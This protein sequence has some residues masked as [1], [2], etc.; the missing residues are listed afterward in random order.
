MIDTVDNY[1]L[2]GCMRCDFGATP[3][4]K[5]LKWTDALKLLRQIVLDCGL[6]EEVKWG[7]PCYSYEGSNVLIL[8]A[9]VDYCSVNFFKGVLIKDADDLL[10]K[11]GPNSQSSR[12]MKFTDVQQIME[13]EDVLKS[14]IHQAIEVEKA[15]LKVALKKDPEPLPEELEL[16]FKE[17]PQF[18]TAF[19]SLTP[20]R[21]RGYI[22]FFSGA[23]QS[24]T[25]LAR[26]EK[27]INNIL[28]G[29]GMHDHYKGKKK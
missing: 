20:G 27:S 13:V 10:V 7:V 12:L 1:L 15:G 25:R 22:L 17:D 2:D 6:H 14:Y 8:S 5:V 16:K 18:R 23:K 9:F 4:C 28:N 24:K 21:Q 11:P 19:E 3:H 26:I 29:M